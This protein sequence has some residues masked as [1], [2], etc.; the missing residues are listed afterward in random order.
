MKA[1]R[2]LAKLGT[3][4]RMR[5]WAMATGLMLVG[6]YYGKALVGERPDDLI[7][8][9]ATAIGGFEL[10]LYGNDLWRGRRRRNG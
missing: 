4:E 1:P 5:A 7:A 8:M 3:F 2:K 10:A 6:W 9:L